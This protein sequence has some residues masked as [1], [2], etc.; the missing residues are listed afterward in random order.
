MLLPTPSVSTRYQTLTVRSFGG[1][2]LLDRVIE[3]YA[4]GGKAHLALQAS[5]QTV[6][7]A[8]GALGAHHGQDGAQHATV[9]GSPGCLRRLVLPL[10]LRNMRNIPAE[11]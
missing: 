8:A 11:T 4:D 7:G 9:L 10:D 5:D 2:E 3:A 6:V 1:V